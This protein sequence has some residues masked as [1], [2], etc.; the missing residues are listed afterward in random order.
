MTTIIFYSAAIGLTGISWLK[1]KEKT[2]KA[3]KKAYKAFFN[4]LPALI[5]MVLFVGLMLTLIP[6][7]LIGRILGD[8]AGAVGVAVGTFL[9]SI[10]F[11]PSFVAFSLGE[12]LLVGGAGYAQVAAFVAS[13]MAVGVSS[14]NVENQYFGNKL[15]TYRNIYAVFA[16]V[17]FAIVIG[18]IL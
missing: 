12:N 11:M 10:V 16:S 7:S 4:L 2:K 8:E 5:P 17:V 15:T 18:V 13:L 3:L 1:N 6:P 9:G 14:L